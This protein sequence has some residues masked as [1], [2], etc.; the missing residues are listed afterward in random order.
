MIL[1][2]AMT[3]PLL[4][5]TSCRSH[6]LSEFESHVGSQVGPSDPG[7]AVLVVKNGET[8]LEQCAGVK[9]LNA[10]QPI[11]PRTNFRLASV[12]KQF[13]ASAILL[14]VSDSV[15]R[16]DQQLTEIFP[17]FPPYG[18]TI[19]IWHLLTHTSGLPDYESL[20]PD[21]TSVPVLDRDVL[22]LLMTQKET[23]FPPGSEFRYSNSGY[24]I[25][26]QVVERISGMRFADFLKKRIF[27]P[28]A[29]TRTVAYEKGISTVPDRAFG[30][31]P[32]EEGAFRET[33]Q[34]MTSAVLGDGGIY[35][36]LEDLRRWAE[37]LDHPSV[38]NSVLVS[39]AMQAQVQTSNEG[40]SYGYGWYVDEYAG[41]SRIR[42]SGSTIGFRTEVQRYPDL[43]LTVVVL[44][45]RADVKTTE[46][47]TALA[48]A[49]MN[50]QSP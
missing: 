35:S 44:A 42:H 36:C 49:A 39:E 3:L 14:L 25:L 12:T 5:L 13:T 23:L 10:K 29:M 11:T 17:E 2:I 31:S 21:S 41:K 20:M 40:E 27:L 45:N 22:R 16:L 30:H 46:L 33:D 24:A 47:A 19:T 50:G 9:D 28:L 34:S 8:L 4:L 15:L 48:V 43:G 32:V 6:L 7:C 1:R 38:L 37:E 26:A 18:S